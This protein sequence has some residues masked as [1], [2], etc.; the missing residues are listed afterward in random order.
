MIFA[1]TRVS[2]FARLHPEFD[3]EIQERAA[4]D[5]CL[6]GQGA[7]FSVTGRES[8]VVAMVGRVGSLLVLCLPV[9]QHLQGAA[10][11][12]DSDIFPAQQG[13]EGV[14]GHSGHGSSSRFATFSIIGYLSD[15][16]TTYFKNYASRY[17]SMADTRKKMDR[18]IIQK[19]KN[20]HARPPQDANMIASPIQHPLI[21]IRPSIRWSVWKGIKGVSMI[22]TP[23][24]SSALS[25]SSVASIREALAFNFIS[26]SYF[27]RAASNSACFSALV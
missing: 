18:H 6:S 19:Q 20:A 2:G 3:L 10:N 25:A 14:A 11:N 12:M 16:A 26:F 7:L 22:S 17:V 5:V 13:G 27:N 8:T 21:Q 15:K 23:F 24:R 4:L 9:H 1:E